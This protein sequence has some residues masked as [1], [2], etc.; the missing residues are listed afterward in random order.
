M[1]N[2]KKLQI[3]T[4]EAKVITGI[5]AAAIFGTLQSDTYLYDFIALPK[6]VKNTKTTESSRKLPLIEVCVRL[7][8][9][10][11]DFQVKETRKSRMQYSAL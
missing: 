7:K 2:D 9:V 1:I 8:E 3:K 11:L 6:N 4:R 5:A 10:F